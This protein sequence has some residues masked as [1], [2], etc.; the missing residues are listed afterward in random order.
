MRVINI[1]ETV[2]VSKIVEQES[3]IKISENK[4][5]RTI[6]V[7]LHVK[8]EGDYEFDDSYLIDGEYYNMLM[9]ES[10]T[11]ARNKPANEYREQDL[12]YI[13]DLIRNSSN[14]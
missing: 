8:C 6:D 7:T 14:Y 13:I 1:K 3:I 10:P 12:L 9:S 4:L 2:T 11:F 5:K